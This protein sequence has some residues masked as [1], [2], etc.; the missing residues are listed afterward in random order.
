MQI[1]TS[2]KGYLMASGALLAL[3]S[4]FAASHSD[5]QTKDESVKPTEVVVYAQRREQR[6]TDVPMAVNV[7]SAS[8]LTGSHVASMKDM[9]LLVPGMLVNTTNNPA[10]TNAHIRGIG[11]VGDNPALE[12]SVGIVVDGVYRPRNGV[13]I[14]N[15][16]DLDHVEV[17]KGPQG[18]LYGKNTT[19]GVISVFS[20][21][22][23]FKPTF[24]ASISAGNLDSTGYGVRVS[25][26]LSGDQ[27]AGSLS[28]GHEENGGFA[29]VIT[30]GGPRS[31]T[32]DGASKTDTFKAQ[33]LAVPNENVELRVIADY[34]HF[35][36]TCCVTEQT[37]VG[38]TAGLINFVAGGAGVAGTAD[39]KARTAYS[40]RDT[41]SNITDRGLAI[42]STIRLPALGDTTLTTT[43][44]I[45]DWD[46]ASGADLD[47]SA[48][49]LLYRNNNGDYSSD[50]KTVSQEFRLFNHSG[51]LD[52]LVGIYL[53]KENLT[54]NDSIVYGRD[55]ERYISLLLTGGKSTAFVSAL[56]GLAPGHT[57]TP[58]EQSKDLYTQDASSA[59]I[60]VNETWTPVSSLELTAGLRYTESRKKMQASYYTT[61]GGIGCKSA[62]TM[63]AQNA[64]AWAALTPGQ[65]ASSLGALCLFWAN[66][67]FSGRTL[68][69]SRPESNLSGT[70][71]A[72][73]HLSS[74]MMA[75]AAYTTG[76]KAGGF[77]QDRAQTGITPD[78][79]L[80]FGKET[81][82]AMEVGLKGEVFNHTLTFN[83]T[84]YYQR[85][86]NFQLNTFIGTAYVVESI[87]EVASQGVDAE[88][89]WSTPIHGLT[90]DASTN[91]N[92]AV[93]S[94]F[95][96][97]ELNNPSHFANLSLLP[98]SQLSFAPK[99][100][101]SIATQWTSPFFG[102]TQTA[103]IVAKYQSS[104]VAGSD[105]ILFKTQK[106]ETLVNA[107]WTLNLPSKHWSVSFWGRN[108]TNRIIREG[109]IGG[110]LQGT[111]FQTTLQPSGNYYNPALD[112][113]TYDAFLG[114]P[115]TYGVTLAAHF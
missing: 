22:P 94:H 21:K 27:L 12:A 11:T 100:S 57:Y 64:G 90:V 37:R 48:A 28:F 31:D 113:N 95:T 17:I 83:V 68:N 60:Y 51:K 86:K 25:G 58:G 33:L 55:Y 98:G 70:L 16:V 97:A 56:T 34:T 74:D 88:A 59:A 93:Y 81:I 46:T 32:L 18:T 23:D 4:G 105:L 85:L 99:W 76:Y 53:D 89:F 38:P 87:P 39:L 7:V 111:G 101:T 41:G 43:T 92:E 5:A 45:R 29:H 50:Y 77:N 30:A 20:K 10:L 40:N 96:A 35:T 54:H 78:S 65:K 82:E 26:P 84:P 44:G 62:E 61:D 71:K 102:M 49:D 15:N 108:L 112:T 47:F 8:E 72:Q 63:F 79:S 104:Y 91:Y 115:R 114:M 109:V 73:Y 52:S 42:I 107:S 69:Q 75:Y 36:S 1:T 66:P 103:T 14:E 13:S 80:Y 9:Q 24:D 106:G 6:L 3:V 110:T 19:A 67:A 2:R